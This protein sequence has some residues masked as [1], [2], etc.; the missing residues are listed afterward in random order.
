LIHPIVFEAG[1]YYD[2]I[3][4]FI[5]IILLLLFVKYNKAHMKKWQGILFL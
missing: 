4:L 2:F 3:V 5:I 1:S